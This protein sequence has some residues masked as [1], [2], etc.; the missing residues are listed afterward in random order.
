M[1]IARLGLILIS[2]HLLFGCADNDRVELQNEVNEFIWQAMNQFYFWQSSVPELDDNI[3]RSSNSLNQ[4]VNGYSSPE[5]LFEDMLF[6]EDRFSWMVSDYEVLDAAFQGI[7][8]SFGYEYGLVNPTGTNQVFGFV[9]YVVP[10]APADKA[11]VQRGHLFTEVDGT[12][13]TLSNYE[14]LLFEPSTYALT[15]GEVVN[16]EVLSRDSVVSMTKAF[17]TE[18]PIHL[19][20]VLDVSGIKVGYL[21]YNQFVNNEA[22]NRELNAVFGS[23]KTEGVSE[24]VLDLRYNPGGSIFTSQILASLIYG[25]ATPSTVFGSIVYN[26]KLNE[27]FADLDLNYYFLDQLESGEALNRLD[28]SRLFVLTSGNTASASELIIA[29]LENY[30]PVTLIG[31]TTVGKNV[32]SVTLYDSPETAYLEKGS[33]LSPNH[34][35]ALQPIISQLANSAGF[36]DYIDGFRPDIEISEVDLI[37]NIRPLGS[38]D[39]QLL[40]EALT[41]ISSAARS[42]RPKPLL[43]TRNVTDSHV[44]KKHIETTQLDAKKLG[45][46]MF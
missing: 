26:E 37:G 1:R 18:N 17:V 9:K 44:L 6:E 29:G 40:A 35:Y 28:I 16:G 5:S 8:T 10:N 7:S 43:S 34:K 23:F 33:D 41:I 25:A 14:S 24:L 30:L 12:P 27:I 21:V 32:G 36:S 46:E 11:G 3:A 4:F 22:Y 39:E 2:I 20:R 15:L 19:S 45:F 38:M 13:L 31:T 42:N